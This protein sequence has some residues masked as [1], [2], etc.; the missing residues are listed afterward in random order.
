MKIVITI[1]IYTAITVNFVSSSYSAFEGGTVEVCIVLE[2]GQ[3]E[4]SVQFSLVS[5]SDTAQEGADYVAVLLSV[6]WEPDTSQKCFSVRLVGDHVVEGEETFQIVL[7][8]HDPSVVVPTPGTAYI[9]IQ[10]NDSELNQNTIYYRVF[11]SRLLQ[12][13]GKLFFEVYYT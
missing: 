4:R 10:D 5:Q 12:S 8:S 2:S 9:T 3:L 13:I 7:A 1:Y 6:T 11:N